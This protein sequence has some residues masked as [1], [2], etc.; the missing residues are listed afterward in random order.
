MAIGSRRM[1]GWPTAAAVA[2]EPIVAARYT[3]CAQLND[4]NTRGM[5]WLWRPPKMKALTGTP[6]GSS[7]WGSIDGHCAAGTVKRAFGWA[8][9]VGDSGVQS[10]PCQSIRWAGG[11]LIPSHHTSPSS[12]IAT[13]VKM[14]FAESIAIAFG[15]DRAEVPGATPKSP[16]SG[17]IA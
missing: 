10:R 4:W 1:A 17:L 11:S 15:F 7:Q 14:Q 5:L 8:A 6:C 3:P 16:A 9:G 12:V 13:L 2:S